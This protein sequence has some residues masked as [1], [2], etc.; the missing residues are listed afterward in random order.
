MTTTTV[1]TSAPAASSPISAVSNTLNLNASDFMK[2]MIKQLQNQD[3]LNPTN[4][5]A[6]MQQMSQIGQMQ[7]TSQLQ[8]TLSGLATQTQIGAASNLIGKQVA[9]IDSSNNSVA[10]LVTSVQVSSSGVNLQLD[11][12]SLVPLGNV[13]TIT[14]AAATTAGTTKVTGS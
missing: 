7:S 14:P 10:G 4:S 8:T 1:G 13:T 5:D 6:L 3:P 2:M 9:G 11:S 12:G